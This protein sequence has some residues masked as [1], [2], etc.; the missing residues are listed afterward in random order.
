MPLPYGGAPGRGERGWLSFLDDVPQD[1]SRPELPA[2]RDLFVEAYDREEAARALARQARLVPGTFPE[3][4]N[5]MWLTWTALIQEL[6]QQGNLRRCVEAASTDPLVAAYHDRFVEMLRTDVLLPRPRE[7]PASTVWWRGDDRSPDATERLRLE[8]LMHRRSRLIG[9]ELAVGVAAAAGSVAK[10]AIRFGHRNASGTG[11]LINPD[12]LLTNHHNTIHPDY[13]PSTSIEVDFDHDLGEHDPPLKRSVLVDGIVGERD[14]DWAVLPL[15][16]PVDRAPLPL[17]SPFTVHVDDLLV[18]IQH[19]LGGFKQ[20]ALEPLAVR[21]VDEARIQYVA[22]TQQG[23]S[24]SPVFDEQMHVV[25]LHHAEAEVDD[26]ARPDTIR[27]N[28]GIAITRIIAGLRTH[29]I[30]FQEPGAPA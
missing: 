22:D 12:R 30:P 7:M 2:L 9:V 19:P 13:G 26:P 23:S 20:F 24:G 1:W 4:N 10:L 27:R 28:Q 11:F 16:S 8:R 14:D 6:G 21:H 25:A 17:G 18:I 29:E 3:R 15:D 5:T